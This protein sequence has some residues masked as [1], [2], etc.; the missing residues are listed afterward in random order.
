MF[1]NARRIRQAVVV[2]TL[3]LGG[4]SSPV[5]GGPTTNCY[6]HVLDR[7]ND[8]LGESR[9]WQKPAVGVACS[10]MMGGC[11]FESM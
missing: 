9:W 2:L 3:A 6:D 5:F 7:C 8:A 11:A 4:M 10:L 1:R